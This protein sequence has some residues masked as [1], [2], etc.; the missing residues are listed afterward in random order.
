MTDKIVVLVT[1]GNSENAALLAKNLVERRL[2]ACA[3]LVPGVASWYWWEGRVTEDREVLLVIKTS[4]VKFAALEKE[5]LRLHAYAVPEV[6]AL[7]I[8]EG[9]KNYLDWIDESLEGPP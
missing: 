1:V 4:R 2:A 9:S 3:S 6:I 5:V 7:Q 8:V